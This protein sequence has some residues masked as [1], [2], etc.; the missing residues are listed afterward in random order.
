M[1]QRPLNAAQTKITLSD[2]GL[3]EG[4]CI[5][6]TRGS[7]FEQCLGSACSLYARSHRRCSGH[8]GGRQRQQTERERW[9]LRCNY[10]LHDLSH[11]HDSVVCPWQLFITWQLNASSHQRSTGCAVWMTDRKGVKVVVVVVERRG[12]GRGEGLTSRTPPQSPGRG[13]ACVRDETVSLSGLTLIGDVSYIQRQ[14]ISV[15]EEIGAVRG[16]EMI[17]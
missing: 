10:A 13:E 4:T 2:S 7:H 14:M 9:A 11:A 8:G 6:V 17:W 15:W 12:G 16:R 1:L 3:Y 5:W